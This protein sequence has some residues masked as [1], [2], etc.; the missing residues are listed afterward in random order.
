[1]PEIVDVLSAPL[2]KGAQF[3]VNT[4]AASVDLTPVIIGTAQNMEAAGG[5]NRF[6][7]GDNLIILSA[8]YFIPENF[9]LSQY[10]A[11]GVNTSLP[12]LY[13]AGQSAPGPSIPLHCWGNSGAM[14]IPFPCYEIA[15]GV[16]L[17][18]ES[19]NLNAGITFRIQS[20][21][22]LING[23]VYPQI[24]MVNVPAALNG[25]TIQ[26]TPFIKILHNFELT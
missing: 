20:L 12:V 25:L 23:G 18:P 10:R 19:N 1:M 26:V 15:S 11:G 4:A 9:V 22:P 17:D 7:Q 13:L 2:G 5:V 16:F 8:G 14:M 6:R 21:F 3:I 24:S